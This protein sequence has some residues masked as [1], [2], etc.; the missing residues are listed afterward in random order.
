MRKKLLPALVLL[1]AVTAGVAVAHHD[2]AFTFTVSPA[3]AGAVADTKAHVE[4]GTSLPASS[5][6]HLP[7]GVLMAH[8]D[9]RTSPVSPPPVHGDVVGGGQSYGDLFNDGCGNYVIS[10]STITWV[11]PI[12]SGAPA[13]TVAELK[14][15]GTPLPGLTITKRAF[16]VKSSGDTFFSGAHYDLRIPDM[17][18]EFACSGSSSWT[19]LTT[20]GY[21]RSGGST[22]TRVVGRNP[23]TPG[24]YNVFHE[25]TDTKRVVHQDAHS[26]TVR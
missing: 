8:A 6:T 24:T 16:I 2:L 9:D 21:A 3:T 13:G 22:T 7:P 11:E 15:Q 25:Y 10:N 14:M 23:S 17:P 20:Y 4:A 18:D 12:G 19:D 5:V 26:F 1:S